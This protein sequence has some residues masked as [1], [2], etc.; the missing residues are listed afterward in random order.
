MPLQM[1]MRILRIVHSQK[2]HREPFKKYK[3]PCPSFGGIHNTVLAM[4]MIHIAKYHYSV[5]FMA[6]AL[7]VSN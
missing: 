7:I 3:A 6:L 4:P 5:N 1:I 2:A